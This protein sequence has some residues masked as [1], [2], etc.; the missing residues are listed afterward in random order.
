MVF[1]TGLDAGIA[2][3]IALALARYVGVKKLDKPFAWIASGA[4][5]F[6]ASAATS[7]GTSAVVA[8]YSLA[9]IGALSPVL[10]VAG[11]VAVLVGGVW[12]AY[13]LIR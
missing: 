6:I 11:F 7:I 12:A 3:L 9:A 10:A 8:G 5:L 1:G 4:M 2:V 13:E